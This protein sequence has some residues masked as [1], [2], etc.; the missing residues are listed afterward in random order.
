MGAT[1]Q[2]VQAGILTSRVPMSPRHAGKDPE[3]VKEGGGFQ[4]LLAAP[5]PFRCDRLRPAGLRLANPLIIPGKSS[6]GGR[7][8]TPSLLLAALR[9]SCLCQVLSAWAFQPPS[10]LPSGF[11]GA[12][13]EVILCIFSL[14]F[15]WSLRQERTLSCRFLYLALTIQR[16]LC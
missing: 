14:P 8:W 7:V 10:S 4:G 16:I 6:P 12:G 1:S 11:G 2:A 5:Q 3:L 15:P 13:G 9:A